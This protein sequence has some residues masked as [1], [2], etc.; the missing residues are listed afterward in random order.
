MNSQHLI[1]PIIERVSHK[2]YLFNVAVLYCVVV[3]GAIL[4][5]LLTA[6]LAVA[7]LA[8][9]SKSSFL[10]ASLVI[11]SV[12]AIFAFI[13]VWKGF[14]GDW[15]W[16]T[17]HYVLLKDLDFSH[18]YGRQIGGIPI[19]FT[20]PIYYSISYF[21]SRMT[22]A[23][24]PALAILIT[25]LIYIPMG[26]AVFNIANKFLTKSYDVAFVI[27]IVLLTGITFTL[28]IQ[29]VRQE[30]ASAI[31]VSALV[32]L[33]FNRNKAGCFLLLTA[34]LTH[35]SVLVPSFF[36]AFVFLL[37]KRRQSIS[38]PTYVVFWVFALLLGLAYVY[39]PGS[40]YYESGRS[41]GEISLSVVLFD[42]SLLALMFFVYKKFIINKF[43]GIAV[44][45]SWILL[46]LAFVYSG[47]LMGVS[48]AP[49]PFLRMY[50]YVEL[51]RAL[52]IAI[53]LSVFLQRQRSLFFYL[54]CIVVAIGYVYVRML[55]APYFYKFDIVSVFVSTPFIS[56]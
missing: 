13:N 53:L 24:I 2:S 32:F 50:F 11:F 56:W 8:Y 39:G 46:T 37:G 15:N 10:S 3:I 7:L 38:V 35:N 51:F 4:F 54:C 25:F 31:F 29:L 49:I 14:N 40:S 18:Y 45:I 41:D 48:I 52:M 1:M 22:G 17:S 42:I 34:C 47:F 43:D 12:A 28:T 20:E 33:F 6:V 26:Y 5:P 44:Q 27:C 19:K 21:T 9:V 55:R 30:I 23:N 16:Y 36:T